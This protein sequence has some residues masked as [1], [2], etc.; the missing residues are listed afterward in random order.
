MH[1]EWRSSLQT[2]AWEKLH[3]KEIVVVITLRGFFQLTNALESAH[4]NVTEFW[5]YSWTDSSSSQ[6]YRNLKNISKYFSLHQ[7]MQNHFLTKHCLL[8]ILMVKVFQI[9]ILTHWL[10]QIMI[11]V[12]WFW[13]SADFRTLPDRPN[14]RTRSATRFDFAEN[15]QFPSIS[16]Q[17]KF[18]IF[19]CY[20]QAVVL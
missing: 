2:S 17:C 10:A 12:H 9:L 6:L 3:F 5:H 7:S 14:I 13:I 1:Q 20:N 11:L 19:W 18:S 16:E 15:K 4:K 8:N